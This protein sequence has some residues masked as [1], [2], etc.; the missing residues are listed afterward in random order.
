MHGD[1]DGTESETDN[2]GEVG[3]RLRAGRWTKRTLWKEVREA[4]KHRHD[5]QVTESIHTLS[6]RRNRTKK[7]RFDWGSDS[8]VIAW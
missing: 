1:T 3:G 7:V 5:F 6:G 4:D 2:R 8:P